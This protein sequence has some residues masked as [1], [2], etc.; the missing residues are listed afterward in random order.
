[1]AEN[2]RLKELQ[3]KIENQGAEIRRL[4]DLMELRDQEQ[5]AHTDQV[6][7]D[8]R[9]RMEQFQN[10]LE[11]FMQNYSQP[12][13]GS[14]SNTSSPTSNPLHTAFQVK[15]IALGFPHF[16]GH[17]PVL[18][19]IFKAEK[20]FNYHHTPDE[21]QV[22]IAAIHF[23]KDVVPWFQMLQRLSAITSWHDLTRAL[24]SQFGPSPFD[25]PMADLFKLQQTGSVSEYYLKFM[26]LANRSFGLTQEALLN[27]F[28]SGLHTE[29]RRDVVAQSPTSLL[30]AV[31][32]AKLYEDRYSPN[33]K[34][35]HSTYTQKTQISNASHYL[36]PQISPKPFPKQSLPP[37]LPTPQA[38]PLRNSNVRRISPVEMQLRREKGL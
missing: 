19:W 1:M 7:A 17:T 28:L 33:Q 37:L 4:M 8:A 32:L 14:S 38:P 24:E 12:H 2:T 21:E 10:A 11:Q 29:I 27:C 25:C 36:P 9:Q 26:S 13:G 6:Q 34:F 30:R 3:A 23:E 18:E 5:R 35:Q 31:A 20:F 15:D 16:D 22:D